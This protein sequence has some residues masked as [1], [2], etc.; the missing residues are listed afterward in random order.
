M[1]LGSLIELQ[2]QILIAKDINYISNETFKD[3]AT[4][5]IKVS[6]LINGMKKKYRSLIH[7]S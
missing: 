1:A 6:K 4:R 5:T 2:N 3:I 7:N